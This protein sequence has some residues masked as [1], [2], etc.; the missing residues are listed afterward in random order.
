ML[1]DPEVARI[2][3]PEATTRLEHAA[4]HPPPKRRG[5]V[6]TNCA[7][8]IG[9]GWTLLRKPKGGTPSEVLQGPSEKVDHHRDQRSTCD[10][11][12]IQPSTPDMGTEEAMGQSH[13]EPT[14]PTTGSSTRPSSPDGAQSKGEAC[15]S[16]IYPS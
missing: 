9:M 11:R 4:S 3:E 7:D 2:G 12:E 5:G 8:L 16:A 10:V 13:D 15:G 14:T 6:R 1:D